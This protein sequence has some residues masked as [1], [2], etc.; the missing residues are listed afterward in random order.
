MISSLSTFNKTLFVPERGETHVQ[1]CYNAMLNGGGHFGPF[2]DIQGYYTDKPR[3]IEDL[4]AHEKAQMALMGALTFDSV[5]K[6]I[7]KYAPTLVLKLLEKS[8]DKCCTEESCNGVTNLNLPEA[9]DLV[10]NLTKS[11]QVAYI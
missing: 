2:V 7:Q 8:C 1:A 10:Q 6:T 11:H 9:L 3:V 4:S 5:K